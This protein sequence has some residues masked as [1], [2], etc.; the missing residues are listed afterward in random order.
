MRLILL[1]LIS[2]SFGSCFLEEE[3]PLYEI[4]CYTV[5]QQPYTFEEVNAQYV[6]YHAT[7]T[8]QANVVLHEVYDQKNPNHTEVES[9]KF[10]IDPDHPCVSLRTHHRSNTK[11]VNGLAQ[12]SEIEYDL[13]DFSIFEYSKH[14]SGIFA[15]K[16]V[17][18]GENEG[19]KFFLVF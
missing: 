15:D 2:L 13:L 8:Q 4:K 7:T 6:N 16:T 3:D 19:R 9:F 17:I 10:I 1:F 5:G 18:I 14:Q 11:V 12:T